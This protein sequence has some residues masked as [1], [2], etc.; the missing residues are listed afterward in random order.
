MVMTCFLVYQAKKL[1]Q[2]WQG[3]VVGG[4]AGGV[5]STKYLFH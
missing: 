3:V 4:G 1:N 2:V 5:K